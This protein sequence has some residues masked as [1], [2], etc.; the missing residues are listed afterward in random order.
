LEKICVHGKIADIYIKHS[1]AVAQPRI[2]FMWS[3]KNET[4]STS[5]DYVQSQS[6]QILKC[7]GH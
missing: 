1:E 5:V 3:Q 2:L 6:C 4:L 7:G